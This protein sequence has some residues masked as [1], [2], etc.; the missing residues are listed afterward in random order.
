MI[1]QYDNFLDPKDLERVVNDTDDVSWRIQSSNGSGN[2]FLH[3][4]VSD[5]EYYNKHLWGQLR[6]ILD[7]DYKV[8]EIYFNGQWPG[9]DGSLHIDNCVRTVLLYVNP[10]RPE[11]GGFTQLISGDE[12]III[13]PVQN[14]L[15][16]FDGNIQHK[17]YAFSNQ[18]CPMRITLAFKLK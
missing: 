14:R 3:Y 13:P 9:R 4:D 8:D 15:I 2:D 10:S 11:W 17:G 18:N 6:P 7:G 5:R 1:E 12:Q 16:V